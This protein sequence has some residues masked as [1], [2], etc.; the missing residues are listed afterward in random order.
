MTFMRNYPEQNGQCERNR[1]KCKHMSVQ[2]HG[3]E[4]CECYGELFFIHPHADGQPEQEE[5]YE[6]LRK[7]R[8][9]G[10]HTLFQ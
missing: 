7:L 1:P 2:E 10:I 9:R 5:F 6:R 4:G 8:I 3:F